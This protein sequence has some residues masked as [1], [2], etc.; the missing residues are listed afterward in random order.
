MERQEHDHQHAHQTAAP[1]ADRVF[2]TEG[3]GVD[4][5]YVRAKS[6][7][8]KRQDLAREITNRHRRDRPVGIT[9]IASSRKGNPPERRVSLAQI[10]RI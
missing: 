5:P 10:K 8:A 2:R 4:D 7:A 6:L 9:R 1:K 3:D